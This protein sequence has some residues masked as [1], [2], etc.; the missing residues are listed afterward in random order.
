MNKP[1]NEMNIARYTLSI[2]CI[3]QENPADEDVKFC[4]TEICY[5]QN[6]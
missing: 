3:K 5:M 1:Y 4:A 6:P 2:Y